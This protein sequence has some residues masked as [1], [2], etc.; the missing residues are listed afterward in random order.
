MVKE[1]GMTRP[2]GGVQ[3]VK[4]KARE[5]ILTLAILFF[6]SF[7]F[8]AF[9]TPIFSEKVDCHFNIVREEAA[10]IVKFSPPTAAGYYF[11]SCG[12]IYSNESTSFPGRVGIY[13]ISPQNEITWSSFAYAD[14]RLSYLRLYFMDEQSISSTASDDE[15]NFTLFFPG[16][17]TLAPHLSSMSVYR[18]VFPPLDIKLFY[19]LSG[20]LG[21][22]NAE[23][24]QWL[25]SPNGWILSLIGISITVSPLLILF[26]W[27]L[28]RGIVRS[29]MVRITL[30]KVIMF[31]LFIF[32]VMNSAY[33]LKDLSGLQ[34]SAAVTVRNSENSV[35]TFS[36][37]LP[38]A[39]VNNFFKW[40]DLNIKKSSNTVMLMRGSSQYLQARAAYFLYPRKIAFIDMDEL[41]YADAVRHYFDD[42]YDAAISFEEIR[43]S[44]LGLHMVTSY[45]AGSGFIYE[46]RDA[47]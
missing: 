37:N 14:E 21:M 4:P 31:T 23:F 5:S 41:D 38:Y 12:V 34:T 15:G 47:N 44:A 10:L 46:V 11:V 6:L 42:G 8:T 36:H 3:T 16:S 22:H 30:R 43:E 1:R 2:E 25:S 28:D 45:R 9:F 20:V 7:F 24:P 17:K 29:R 33:F 19:F 35:E 39:S 40:C 13:L 18:R 27:L 26:A 32:L